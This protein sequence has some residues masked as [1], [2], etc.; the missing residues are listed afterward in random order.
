[1]AEKRRQAGKDHV[2]RRTIVN[3]LR[4]GDILESLRRDFKELYHFYIDSET[5]ERLNHETRFRRFIH[6]SWYLLKSLIL[7]LNPA[8]RFLLL[9]SIAFFF[10]GESEIVQGEGVVRIDGE[11]LLQ[12]QVGFRRAIFLQQRDGLIVQAV[13]LNALVLGASGDG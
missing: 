3:D 2:L 6:A 13:D 11:R 9:V 5:Q 4:E 8:R 12:D 7:K 1:M 10:F